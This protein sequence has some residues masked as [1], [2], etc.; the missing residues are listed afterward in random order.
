MIKAV[1]TC[2]LLLATLPIA[3]SLPAPLAAAAKA[4][5]PRCGWVVNPTP[6]NWSLIDREGEW[7]MGMQGGYQARGLDTMPDLSESRWVV[8][9]GSSYG[10]GCACMSADVDRKAKRVVRIRGVRQQSLAICRADH[11]LKRPQG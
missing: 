9:N 8:T 7:V 10:Y 2:A 3:A 6:A 11:K 4:P 1:S 5:A